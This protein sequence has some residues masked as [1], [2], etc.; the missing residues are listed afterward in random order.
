MGTAV[1]GKKTMG[2]KVG[3]TIVLPIYL[4]KENHIKHPLAMFIFLR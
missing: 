4:A 3:M 1:S 2:T